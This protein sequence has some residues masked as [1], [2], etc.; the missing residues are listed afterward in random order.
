[1]VLINDLP[2]PSRAWPTRREAAARLG[3]SI[4]SVRRMEFDCLQ[5][6]ADERGIWRFD[7]HELEALAARIPTRAR[8]ARNAESDPRRRA[9]R[10][11]RA[12][13][14]RIAAQVFQMFSRG[15][16]LPQIVVATKGPPERIRALYHE[17]STSL[18]EHEWQRGRGER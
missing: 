15:W 7:P 12:R 9:D 4:S 5:P 16:S 1:M 11:A 10:R 18:D 14:G 8:A 13:D 6:V 3:I 17:W 2:K